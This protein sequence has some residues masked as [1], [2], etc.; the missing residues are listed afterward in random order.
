V[1]LK[2]LIRIYKSGIHFGEEP[3]LQ[4]N[5]RSGMINF[6][7][8]RLACRSCYTPETSQQF[9]GEDFSSERFLELLFQ[10][11][12]RGAKNINLITPSHIWSS[13]EQPLQD[14]K[15]K[16]SESIPIL[17]K[18]GGS[19]PV[20]LLQSMTSV[21]DILV[22]DFKVW[23]AESALREHLP[24]C[25]GETTLKGVKFAAELSPLQIHPTTHQIQKGILVRHLL[26][27]STPLDTKAILYQ[28]RSIHF[29]GPINLMT[30]FVDPVRKTLHQTPPDL[31]SDFLDL[32]QKLNLHIWVDGA[33]P[34]Q[35]PSWRRPV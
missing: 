11:V 29:P 31:I 19:E 32:A 35:T 33:P 4:G 14:F 28:L 23:S 13:L 18:L 34:S 17:L 1:A 30:R 20:R 3:F 7:G 10:L 5:D 21:A 2:S 22:I 12:Q 6:S 25:Y 16:T 15:E 27:P 24:T 9:L 26:L 8:C